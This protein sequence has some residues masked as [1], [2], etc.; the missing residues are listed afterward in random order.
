MHPL[1][2]VIV[3]QGF[4]KAHHLLGL[5]QVFDHQPVLGQIAD[6]AGFNLHA[7]FFQH[8]LHLLQFRVVA[9]HLKDFSFFVVDVVCPGLQG[10]FGQFV[11]I[12]G[13]LGDLDHAFFVKGIHH[14][15]AGAQAAPGL[16]KNATYR[17]DGSV[18]VV[19]QAFHNHRHLGRAIALVDDFV[20]VVALVAASAFLNG[21]FDVVGR[22][23]HRLGRQYG[24]TQAGVKV[25]VFPPDA[26]CRGDLAGHLGEDLA[27]FGIDHTFFVLDGTPFTMSRHK[28]FPR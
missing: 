20:I 9:D 15:V 16:V 25:G 14:A 27:P 1:H 6:T 22:H 13:R 28:P 17:G 5:F 12:Q 21:A 23:V 7:F 19:A 2:V 26:G 11:F 8:A 10:K 24:S 4:K 18:F 3:F